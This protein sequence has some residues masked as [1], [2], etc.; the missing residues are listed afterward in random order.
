M[1]E[2]SLVIR[3]PRLARA[4]ATLARW[5]LCVQ[6]AGT[7]FFG[8]IHRETLASDWPV[9]S[10][11][12][13]HPLA[14]GAL[15]ALALAAGA[16]AAVEWWI[17]RRPA[18]LAA[19]RVVLVTAT[20]LALFV[21]IVV[22][23]WLAVPG[24]VQPAVAQAGAARLT[25]VIACGVAAWLARPHALEAASALGVA[26]LV[27]SLVAIGQFAVQGSLGLTMLGE[28][29]HLDTN[30]TGV[31]VVAGAG[32]NWLRAYGLAAHPNVLGGFLV[33][34]LLLLAGALYAR[35]WSRPAGA[36]LW[37]LIALGL[38]ALVLSFS[39]SAW[40][41]LLTGAAVLAAGAGQYVR[42]GRRRSVVSV[43]LV[44]AVVLAV[45]LDLRDLIA[46]RFFDTGSVLEARSIEERVHYAA[47]ALDL[48]ARRPWP[49]YGVDNFPL[50]V[51]Q[52]LG[53]TPL[54]IGYPFV[55]NVALLAAVELGV[56][57][58]LAWVALGVLGLAVLVHAVY[59]ARRSGHALD[60]W[61]LALG[62][63]WLALWVIG[64]FDYYLW[65]SVRNSMMWPVL[66]GMWLA[67]WPDFGRGMGARRA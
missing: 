13:E 49:G 46:P 22:L 17:E 36:A 63:A 15:A 43:V 58:G 54:Q 32:R 4:L 21:L 51:H 26:L 34:A 47:V 1:S 59:R 33:V 55:H 18:L 60:A 25:L 57:G 41:G 19:P 6:L 67:Y 27:Q 39:R 45:M 66:L 10:W 64:L 7:A 52:L 62:A 14:L 38:V 56:P 37:A 42:A 2:T 23:A 20:V 3:A 61:P 24:A 31:S 28:L 53:L 9:L 44:A 50:A 11:L 12:R 30:V 48:I 5:L 40:V 29:P 35:A 65:S 8:A 16:G